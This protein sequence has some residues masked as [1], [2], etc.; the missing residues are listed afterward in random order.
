MWTPLLPTRKMKKSPSNSS[1]VQLLRGAKSSY[2]LKLHSPDNCSSTG[3]GE[4][5]AR[6]AARKAKL[7]KPASNLSVNISAEAQQIA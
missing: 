6:A 1:T 7:K 3:Y 2:A 4:S 5:N